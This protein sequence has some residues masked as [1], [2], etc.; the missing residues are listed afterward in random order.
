MNYP[1]YLLW[2]YINEQGEI[3]IDEMINIDGLDTN[4]L[5][6]KNLVHQLELLGLVEV[7]GSKAVLLKQVM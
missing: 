5:P 7:R 2:S 4:K 6:L 3:R 1:L